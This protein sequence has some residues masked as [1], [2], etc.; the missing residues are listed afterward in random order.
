MRMNLGVK[1]AR[2]RHSSERSVSGV[3]YGVW[4]W[5]CGLVNRVGRMVEAVF[6]TRVF[7]T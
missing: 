4:S 2:V 5:G 6:D 1:L 3:C 7:L